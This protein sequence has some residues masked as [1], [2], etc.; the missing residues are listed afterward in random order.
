MNALRSD[1][2]VKSLFGNKSEFNNPTKFRCLESYE[3]EIYATPLQQECL[4]IRNSK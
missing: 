1:E 2:Y 3:I 4:T